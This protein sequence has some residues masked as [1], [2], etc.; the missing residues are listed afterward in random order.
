MYLYLY[1]FLLNLII[2]IIIIIICL[3]HGFNPTQPDPCGLGLIFLTHHGGLGQKISLTQ[4]NLIHAH[5]HPLFAKKYNE[6]HHFNTLKFQS[7]RME[8]RTMKVRE[9][10]RKE[11]EDWDN[12]EVGRAPFKAFSGQRSD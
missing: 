5:L 11:V 6:S 12:E 3:T 7:L 9:F 1:F 2:I 4:S 8:A 10:I